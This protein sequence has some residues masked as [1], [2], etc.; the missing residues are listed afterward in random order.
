MSACLSTCRCLCAR[1]YESWR[2]RESRG[3]QRAEAFRANWSEWAPAGEAEKKL[4]EKH[5]QCSESGFVRSRYAICA[6]HGGVAQ[7]RS[8]WDEPMAVRIDPFRGQPESPPTFT[9]V[10]RRAKKDGWDQTWSSKDHSVT[11]EFGSVDSPAAW[12]AKRH[13]CSIL[14]SSAAE[15][16]VLTS[17]DAICHLLPKCEMHEMQLCGQVR[18]ES[19]GGH[20][21]WDWSSRVIERVRTSPLLAPKG[22]VKLLICLQAQA[23]ACSRS[24]RREWLYEESGGG[25]GLK[26]YGVQIPMR[27]LLQQVNSIP[28]G[29]ALLQEIRAKLPKKE[30]ARFDEDAAKEVWWLPEPSSSLLSTMAVMSED[31]AA[32]VAGALIRSPSVKVPPMT[33]QLQ[34]WPWVAIASSC[35]DPLKFELK[36]FS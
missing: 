18:N 2:W 15:R 6:A 1:I 34:A 13:G 24:I 3:E 14:N 32:L 21:I 10:P 5:G 17:A 4:A 36:L 29:L 26:G 27:T 7:E 8:L 9:V 30:A 35:Q 22:V 20:A 16:G 25:V 11:I 12:A 23:T 33:S 31:L 28:G 19:L